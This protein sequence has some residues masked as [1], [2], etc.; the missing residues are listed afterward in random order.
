MAY[1]R[2]LL[3]EEEEVHLDLQPHWWFFAKQI[4]SALP[5][6]VV[7][8][9]I[10]GGLNGGV[11]NVLF[12][13]W[14]IAALGWAGWLAKAYFDWR[15]THFVVTS[16]RVIFRT[17]VM[18]KRGV[19]IPLGRIN[20]INFSQGIWERLI[21]AGDLEIESA[22][23]DGQSIFEDV[24][25]PDGVQQ[26]IYRVMEASERRR[27]SWAAPPSPS[28]EMAAPGGPP[29]TAPPPAPAAGGS[30][31]D[32]IEQLARLR[33]QGVL[34]DAEFQAKKQQLLDRM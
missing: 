11:R 20:N 9:L 14:G 8:V 32:Q 30:I 29:P 24:R 19:E 28:T 6:L 10:V 12:A 18:A 34:S 15:F 1:P 26:E 23:K 4:L 7:L 31:P 17:G 33:D 27:A 16:E 21:G 3:R 5:L 2:R 22:G 13:A 25:H